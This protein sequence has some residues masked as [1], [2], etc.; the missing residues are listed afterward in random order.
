MQ[1][2]ERVS[3]LSVARGFPVCRYYGPCFQNGYTDG[4]V[5]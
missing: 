4:C 3:D 5:V 1:L 2:L